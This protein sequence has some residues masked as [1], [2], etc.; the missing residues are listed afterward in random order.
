M[1]RLVAALCAEPVELALA[2]RLASELDDGLPEH[3]RHEEEVVMPW[4]VDVLPE[5]RPELDR[6]M[7]EHGP[8]LA[9]AMMLR[10]SLAS[11]PTPAAIASALRFLG[12][13][14]DHVRAERRLLEEA[15]ARAP[16]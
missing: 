6:L 3:L 2:Q 8:L 15:L 16:R 13:F 11:N 7:Q 14:N 9:G 5:S 12:L 1:Q 4:L 10:R